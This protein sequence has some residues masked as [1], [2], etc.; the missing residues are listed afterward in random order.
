M[1]ICPI[2]LRYEL[3][4]WR[5]PIHFLSSCCQLEENNNIS[6]K[7]QR[8]RV[9]N[10][11]NY[12]KYDS[13]GV[14]KVYWK[15]TCRICW[16]FLDICYAERINEYNGGQKFGAIHYDFSL[17]G[18]ISVSN[19]NEIWQEFTIQREENVSNF[20]QLVHNDWTYKAIII[21]IMVLNVWPPLYKV[22]LIFFS[23]K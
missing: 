6:A 20:P 2:R 15:I 8:E 10:N 19:L 14:R 9:G 22:S 21:I 23:I 12:A 7:M 18:S 4:Y 5:I 16:E 17:L 13:V 3:D 1:E 11:W